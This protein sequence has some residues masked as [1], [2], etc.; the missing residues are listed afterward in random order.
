MNAKIRS[1]QL[2]KVPYMLVV[3]E[4]E[5]SAGRSPCACVM[6]HASIT[7]RSPTSLPGKGSPRLALQPVISTCHCEKL[8]FGDEAISCQPVGAR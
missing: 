3:G 5:A 4:N 6:A 2:M 7:S 1:A 8:F